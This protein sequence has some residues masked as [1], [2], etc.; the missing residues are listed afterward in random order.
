MTHLDEH[1]RLRRATRADLEGIVR[2]ESLA[3]PGLRYL[4]H[5]FDLFLADQEGEFLVAE[6]D[7]QLVACGKLTV[8]PDGSGWLEALRVIP[9]HQGLGVGTQFYRRLS[10]TATA[11]GIAPLRMYT[12]VGNDASRTLAEKHGLVRVA[13]YRG[14]WR[15]GAG[16]DSAAA[17]WDPVLDPELA[18]QLLLPHR[19]LWTGF[20]VMNRTFYPLSRELCA[21]WAV[22]GKVFRHA[23]T[24][25]VMAL[26]ARFMPGHAL[27]I[28]I[29]VGDYRH[30]LA[31]AGHQARLLGVEKIQ[32]MYPPSHPGL[33]DF[34]LGEGFQLESYDCIVMETAPPKP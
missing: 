9:S 15:E 1:I 13:T 33:Q 22:G 20:V 14:A 34:L 31:L 11:R 6:V 21:D 16:S 4:A 32:C 24:G 27:H 2:V 25:T 8:Q 26:G 7:S 3:T 12:N 28:A 10:A 18:A 30:C 17:G 5:V 19:R 23:R 29:A